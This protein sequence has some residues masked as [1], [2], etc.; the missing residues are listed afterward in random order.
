M[1]ADVAEGKVE[2]K[3]TPAY[4]DDFSKE[5]ER[6]I[7]E[8]LFGGL[9]VFV[10]YYPKDIKAF[11]MPIVDSGS[12]I[13]HVDCYDLLFPYVGEVVGGS[14][15]ISD[16][17]DLVSRMEEKKMDLS[18]LQ[19]YIDLRKDASLPHGGAGLGLGRLMIVM[20]GIFNIKDMQEFPRAF[21]LACNA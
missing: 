5:H 9:P 17:D 11:Y 7:T 13:E 6:Y 1:L 15:R 10:R 3:E 18:M 4:G 8:V 21:S 16:H 19:W 20:S 2:F 12:D 14:Q